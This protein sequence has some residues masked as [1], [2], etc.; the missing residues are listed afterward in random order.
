MRRDWRRLTQR[1]GPWPLHRA[2]G[3]NLTGDEHEETVLVPAEGRGYL[4][5]YIMSAALCTRRCAPL[6]HLQG[7]AYC[8]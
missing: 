7:G 5:D 8:S 2:F 3:D 1:R 4:D 6:Q